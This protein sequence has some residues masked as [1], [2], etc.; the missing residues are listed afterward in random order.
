M[1]IRS[2]A[3][4]VYKIFEERYIKLKNDKINKKIK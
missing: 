1:P 4:S 2:V 3:E